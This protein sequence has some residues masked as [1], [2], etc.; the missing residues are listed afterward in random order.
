M[1]DIR[2]DEIQT[3]VKGLIAKEPAAFGK[4]IKSVTNKKNGEGRSRR[5]FS[6]NHTKTDVEF[7]SLTSPNIARP[8]DGIMYNYSSKGLYIESY[9]DSKQNT[10]LMVRVVRYPESA[11]KG[12]TEEALRSMY[13]AE[14][15][16]QSRLEDDTSIRY[17]IG[18]KRL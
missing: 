17:G 10:I 6:R 8:I 11:S 4:N 12:D 2:K 18:L 9:E 14:V 16:W 1:T 7:S 15:K 13:L 3:Y 5:A